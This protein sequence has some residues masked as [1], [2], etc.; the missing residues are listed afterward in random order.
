MTRRRDNGM[1]EPEEGYWSVLDPI[2]DAIELDTP[3]SFELTLRNVPENV[4]L[5][6][7]A[8]FCQSEVC[9]GGFSQ[10]F[11]NSS[12]VLAPEAARGFLLIGQPQV[13]STIQRAMALVGSPFE[14]DRTARQSI[15]SNLSGNPLPQ[16]VPE[17]PQFEPLENEFY[18]LLQSEAGG[19]EAAADRYARSIRSGD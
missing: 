4:G 14:R 5:L 11:W 16:H 10:F 13:S 18:R 8:H 15:L 19:F 12:G 9:N 17:I 6:L 1:V 3:Q 2:C 7:A